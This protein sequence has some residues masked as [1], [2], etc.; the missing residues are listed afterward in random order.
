MQ[1]DKGISIIFKLNSTPPQ[2]AHKSPP[3]ETTSELSR[4]VT[5][6]QWEVG[7]GLHRT[8]CQEFSA[9]KIR[10]GLSEGPASDGSSKLHKPLYQGLSKLI[11]NAVATSNRRSGLSLQALKKTIEATGYDMVKRKNYFKRVL[12]N[13]VTKGGTSASGSFRLGKGVAALNKNAAPR[14]WG[15]SNR[16]GHRSR[17]L[18]RKEQKGSEGAAEEA[19]AEVCPP[20]Q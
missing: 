14:K 3:S 19:K 2:T 9:C 12:L 5:G 11:L 18:G 15:R 16:A 4:E 13:L 17:K 1:K 8:V 20:G 10:V 6:I 7:W